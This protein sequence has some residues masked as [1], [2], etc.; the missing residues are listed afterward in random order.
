[1]PDSRTFEH[2]CTELEK[3][4]FLD[5]LEA[6]GTIRIALKRAGLEASS[7]THEQAEVAIEKIL[8]G[9]L[10]TR[11]IEDA[12]GVCAALRDGLA[13]FADDTRG[14]SPEDV[15]ARLGGS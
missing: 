14:E 5:R 4:T 12:D 9:E 2:V 11:G 13:E 6:R 3:V 1:M 8:A 15:F 10:E 7:L